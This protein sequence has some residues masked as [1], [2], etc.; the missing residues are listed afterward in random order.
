M[1]QIHQPQDDV[2]SFLM[3]SLNIVTWLGLHCVNKDV[4]YRSVLAVWATGKE[5]LSQESASWR[6]VDPFKAYS[7]GP[8]PKPFDF[9]HFGCWSY[10]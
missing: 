3:K 6:V 5:P 2:L 9:F 10:N 1:E 7:K 8:T 4:Q